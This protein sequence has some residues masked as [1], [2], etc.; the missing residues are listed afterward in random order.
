M[1]PP[2]CQ[3]AFHFVPFPLQSG[4]VDKIAEKMV[5]GESEERLCGGVGAG[6]VLLTHIV[7]PWFYFYITTC[8]CIQQGVADVPLCTVVHTN[9]HTSFAA[10]EGERGFFFWSFTQNIANTESQRLQGGYSLVVRSKDP[11]HSNPSDCSPE[12]EPC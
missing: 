9:I 4:L 6:G 11:T 7:K 5:G 3:S 1:V 10:A 8:I 12:E 2:Y